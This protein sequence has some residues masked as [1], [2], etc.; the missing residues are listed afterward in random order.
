ATSSPDRT[1]TLDEPV[2]RERQ[3]GAAPADHSWH[4]D[5]RAQPGH[6]GRR[7]RPGASERR[8]RLQLHQSAHRG[9]DQQRDGRPAARKLQH[10]PRRQRR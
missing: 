9:G 8:Y 2:E 5:I 7:K 4:S 6:G 3:G 10:C 1:G